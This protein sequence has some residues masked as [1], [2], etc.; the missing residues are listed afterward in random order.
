MSERG[1]GEEVRPSSVPPKEDMASSS[2]R[3]ALGIVKDTL[4][5]YLALRILDDLYVEWGQF[6]RTGQVR[7]TVDAET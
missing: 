6:V 1:F 7:P 5:G 2:R 4:P 3:V